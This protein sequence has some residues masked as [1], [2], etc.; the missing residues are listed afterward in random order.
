MIRTS[1]VLAAALS[2]WPVF[3]QP[4]WAQSSRLDVVKTRGV[5]RCGVNPNF[6]GF[7]LPDSKGEWHGFDVDMCRAVASAVFGDAKKTLFVPLSAKDRF[8]A[9][10]TGDI[11]MLARNASW[12]L[13]RNTKLH[14]DFVATNFYDRQAFMVKA[15]SNIRSAAELNGASI[16]VIAGTDTEKNLADFFAGRKMK[17]SSIAYEN[18]DAVAEAYL[19]G[20]CDAFIND[21]TQLAAI[22]FRTPNPADH[23]VLPEALSTEP[24]A[25][26]VR[27]GDD[28]W[29]NIVRWSFFAMVAAEELGL[30]SKNIRSKI[31]SSTNPTVLRFAGKSE[32]LGASLSVNR[33][34]AVRIVEQVGNYGE[35]Y[36]RNIKPLGIERGLNRLWNDGGLMIAPP[37]R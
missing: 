23:V 28:G 9:L 37:I 25:I 7:S 12:T 24:L 2:A 5:L 4:A 31:A 3:H 29:A 27:A 15:S 35:A 17:F 33:D 22:R 34:W 11:D 10:Q 1:I 30:D 19:A 20:R 13:G 36:D 6:A 8:A 14:V 32:D 18:A 16:C 26:S 21:G